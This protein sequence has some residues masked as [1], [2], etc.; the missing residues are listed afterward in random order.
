LPIVPEKEQLDALP[1][2]AEAPAAQPPGDEE[3]AEPCLAAAVEEPE[4][5]FRSMVNVAF[6][7]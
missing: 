6:L 5:W 4:S 3:P 2:A 1:T 7:R